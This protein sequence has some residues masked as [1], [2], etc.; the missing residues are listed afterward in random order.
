MLKPLHRYEITED[1]QESRGIGDDTLSLFPFPEGWYFVTDRRTVLKRRLI[2]KQWMGQDIVVW[3]DDEGNVC[4]AG[5][6]CPHLGSSLGPDAGGRVHGGRLVCPFHGFAY[7]ATGACVATPYAEPPK[8]TRLN[9]FETR[10]IHGLIFAWWG[11]DG[12]PP[13]WHLSDDPPGGAE[14]SRMEIRTLRFPGHPQET[15][16]N[17]VDLAHLRYV[18]GYDNVKP[19]GSATVEGAHLVSRFD[20]RRRRRIAGFLDTTYELSATAHVHGLGFSYVEI[21]EHTIGIDSRMWV[22]PTPVDGTLLD[23]VLVGQVRDIRKPKRPIAGLAFLPE[24][25]RTR[26]MNRIWVFMQRRDVLQDV[27]I[28]GRKKY[29]PHPG[30][31]QSD[32]PIGRYRRYCRQFYP[33]DDDGGGSW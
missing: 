14:W 4:V 12:R 1:A 6:V 27:A 31:C 15:A 5:S 20:F 33:N 16:E 13:Q 30:L 25:L 24:K 8:A 17:A 19:V 21:H 9:V 3:C 11:I 29:R 18:H 32:G 26:I 28:W 10:E 7:D 2:Q 23:L 22:L